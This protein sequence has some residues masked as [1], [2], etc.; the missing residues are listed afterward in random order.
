MK[1]LHLKGLIQ[2]V[3]V[4]KDIILLDYR[5]ISMPIILFECEWVKNEVDSWGDPTYNHDEDGFLLANFCA[6]KVKDD[7]PY[8]FLA[9]VQKVLYFDEVNQPWWKVVF[10]KEP[11]SRHV[12]AKAGEEQPM[13]INIVIGIEALL[14]IP[15]LP[16]N[17]ALGT[18]IEIFGIEAIMAFEEFQGP[19]GD[20]DRTI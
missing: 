7:E 14:E 11:H 13:I 9:Q 3:G 20:E 15:K 10:H 2:Y 18:A 19:S 4:L 5:P 6:L 1:G 17:M 8:V 12:V 16:Q